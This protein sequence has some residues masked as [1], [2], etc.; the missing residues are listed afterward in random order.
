MDTNTEVKFTHIGAARLYEG[1]VRIDVKTMMAVIPVSEVRRLNERWPASIYD[2]SDV[3][4]NSDAAPVGKA[5]ITRS[6]KAVIFNINGVRFVS[7]LSQVKGMLKGERKYA[8][9]AQMH[10]V[11]PF[12]ATKPQAE[13]AS[14]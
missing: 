13:A 4:R 1:S 5:W 8:H 12:A 6:G 3:M 2:I 9:V 7:P 10:E 14:S 11:P